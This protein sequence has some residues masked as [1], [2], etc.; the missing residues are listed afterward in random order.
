MLFRSIGNLHEEIEEWTEAKVYY[1]KDTLE[2]AS[3]EASAI[4]LLR[5]NCYLREDWLTLKEN[6]KLVVGSTEDPELKEF[7]SE[8]SRQLKAHQAANLEDYKRIMD[9]H[10]IKYDDSPVEDDFDDMTDDLM[11]NFP[12]DV[13]KPDSASNRRRRRQP[14]NDKGSLLAG[15]NRIFICLKLHLKLKC[16]QQSLT[17]MRGIH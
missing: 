1:I 15:Q 2:A 5:C 7:L 13:P 8:I 12:D 9:H 6:I 11:E 17:R 16:Y 14:K 3:I 10:K 4:G